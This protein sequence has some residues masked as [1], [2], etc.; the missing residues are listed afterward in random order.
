MM[1]F[2]GR[3][4]RAAFLRDCH[5]VCVW[6]LG[7]YGPMILRG[8]VGF[9]VTRTLTLLQHNTPSFVGFAWVCCLLLRLL[10]TSFVLPIK[11]F[12][13]VV[14]FLA[15]VSLT[16]PQ[17]ALTLSVH[18]ITHVPCVPSLHPYPKVIG[19]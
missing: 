19:L 18:L 7:P 5:T 13:H 10:P 8:C 6:D 11:P 16:V 15:L 2:S 14:T 9:C 12:F 1:H 17:P 3:A 4:A